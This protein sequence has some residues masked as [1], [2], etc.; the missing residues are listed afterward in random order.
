MALQTAMQGRSRQVRNRRL[1]AVETVVE[2]QQGVTAES[3]DNRLVFTGQDRGLRFAWTG[4]QISDRG[5]LLP[6]G[7]GLLIDP[8]S[9]RKRS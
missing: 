2:R 5:S 4:R 9:L 1:Q 6:F 7:N 8:I 3:N